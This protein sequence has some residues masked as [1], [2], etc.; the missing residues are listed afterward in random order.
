MDHRLSF[1]NRRK[2]SEEYRTLIWEYNRF[3]YRIG[4][5]NGEF[6]PVCSALYRTRPS[7]KRSIVTEIG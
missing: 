7:A 4:F 3:Q 5:L 6:R 1:L 2:D